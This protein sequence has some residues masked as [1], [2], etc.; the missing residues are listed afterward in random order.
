MSNAECH[1]FTGETACHAFTRAR[2]VGI[3]GK[4]GTR[5]TPT[6]TNYPRPTGMT[7]LSAFFT[8]ARRTVRPCRISDRYTKSDTLLLR[9]IGAML[10]IRRSGA[11]IL[12]WV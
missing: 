6:Y 2:L 9:P 1:A 5:R 7:R 11:L 12:F 8:V 4:H 3:V 10:L